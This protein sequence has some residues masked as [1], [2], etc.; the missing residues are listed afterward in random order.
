MIA[1]LDTIE[2]KLKKRGFRRDDVLLHE[3]VKC[4]TQAV[5]TYVIM[6]KSGGRDIGLCLECGH[7]VSHRSVAGL[8][9][10]VEDENFD[11]HAFLR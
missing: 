3:C 8:E 6:G 1:D 4:N 5:A 10:R 2:Y 9:S 11:L 7:A